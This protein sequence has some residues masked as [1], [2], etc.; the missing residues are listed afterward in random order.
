MSPPASRNAARRRSQASP[1]RASKA[2]RR[3]SAIGAAFIGKF[4]RQQFEHVAQQLVLLIWLSE[5]AVD[6]D[7]ERALAVLLA[8]TR[9]DHDDRHIAQARVR[10][11]ER[12]VGKG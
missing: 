6:A 10:S 3:G 12:R 8:G 4:L 1:G 5:I 7:V 9:G 11:E 2:T